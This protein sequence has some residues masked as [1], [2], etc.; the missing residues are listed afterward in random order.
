LDFEQA[1]DFNIQPVIT[2][3][4]AYVQGKASDFVENGIEFP[5]FAYTANTDFFNTSFVEEDM[6][7]AEL[8]F[9][10][11]NTINRSYIFDIA[12]LNDNN[13]PTYGGITIVVAPSNGSEVQKEFSL[14]FSGAN[15]DI[16]KSTT[17]MVF[18]VKM[19]PGPP[20]T[21]TSPGRIELSSSITGYFDVR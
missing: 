13:L 18:S 21:E 17:K 12:F 4:L 1:N 7:K 20:L 3:N 16:L 9:K 19:L 2:T 10:V 15:I 8:Y 5:A 6:V 14:I 11:K